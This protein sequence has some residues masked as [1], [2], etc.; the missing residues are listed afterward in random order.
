[1]TYSYKYEEKLAKWNTTYRPRSERDTN[2]PWV[3]RW[4]CGYLSQMVQGDWNKRYGRP[5]QTWW[6]IR[7]AHWTF[8]PWYR[9]DLWAMGWASTQLWWA[10]LRLTK[11]HRFFRRLM[12]GIAGP[13]STRM[14]NV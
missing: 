13:R 12:P 9:I 7:N 1:M 11:A 8:W 3:A 2:A 4:A 5:K 10:L 14:A 6:S